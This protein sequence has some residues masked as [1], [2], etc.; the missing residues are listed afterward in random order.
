[1]NA[2][3]AA[4]DFRVS[5][6]RSAAY[7][8]FSRAFTYTGAQAAPFEVS[9]TE[10]LEAFDPSASELGCSLREGS[11]NEMDQSALFEELMRFYGFF[12]L[13]RGESAEMP[14]HLSVEL[15]FM[16][17][18]THLERDA[19]ASAE[20]LLSLRRAQHDFLVRHVQRLVHGI[21]AALRTENSK[22]LELVALLAE[23]VDDEI[24][25]ARE[26]LNQEFS[27]PA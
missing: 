24:R 17:F 27:H 22:C 16:H 25:I 5:R 8:L 14:D 13:G 11:Y 4:P 6:D 3:A 26:H 10:F 1:V 9:A 2:T 15:E 21:R 19:G 7:Q 23:F 18:L 12:G 20:V